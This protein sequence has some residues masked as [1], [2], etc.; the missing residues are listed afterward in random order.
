MKKL[1][2]NI[3]NNYNLMKMIKKN[4]LVKILRKKKNKIYN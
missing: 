1:L 2:K 4:Y 3:N